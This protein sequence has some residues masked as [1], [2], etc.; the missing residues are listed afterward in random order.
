MTMLHSIEIDT[1]NQRQVKE[2]LILPF[3]IYKNT[4]QWVPPLDTDARSL[5]DRRRHPFYKHSEAAFF[6]TQDETGMILGRLA[7]LDN[8]RYNDFNHERTAFFYLFECENN[9]EAAQCLFQAAFTWAHG[10]GLT[11]ILGPK[12][13]T[14]LDGLGLL[15]KGFEHRPAFGLPYNLEF[16][17]NLVEANGFEATNDI[18]SGYLEPN[19]K[20]P[21]RLH[22]ASELIQKRRGL[23]IARYKTRKDLRLLVPRLKELYNA[24]LEGTS[25]NVPLTDEEIKILADQMLWFADP[26]LVKIIMKDDEPVGFLFAYPDISAALQRTHGR[27]FPFGWLDMLLELKRTKWI[28]INGAG[29]LEKYRGLGGTAILFSEM[30]KS[31]AESRYRYADIVQI[32]VENDKMQREL[33]DLGINF[34]KTHRL[35]QRII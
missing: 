19:M 22:R 2:F 26:R 32:G 16:Y 21:D 28:N 9:F 8:K 10:R 17:A 14:A 6:L 35:Y 27:L 29:I 7:V 20:F 23:R 30:Y 4:P 34:Y 33:T 5:L 11:K 24:S 3:R 13:F 18:V 12:G 25:G 15:V 1:H 31:V